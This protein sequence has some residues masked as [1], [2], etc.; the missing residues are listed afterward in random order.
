M[1]K[2]VNLY[3]NWGSVYGAYDISDVPVENLDT[4]MFTIAMDDDYMILALQ[5]P[6]D[7]PSKKKG[8]AIAVGRFNRAKKGK[9]YMNEYG[10]YPNWLLLRKKL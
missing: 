4:P 7:A 5:H 1:N 9:S 8:W 2:W 3:V 10:E 6:S